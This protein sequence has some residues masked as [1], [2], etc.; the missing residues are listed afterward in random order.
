[1]RGYEQCTEYPDGTGEEDTPSVPAF[2]LFPDERS[3]WLAGCDERVRSAKS[4]E[5]FQDIPGDP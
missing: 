5:R 4:D 1:L 2:D 3:G